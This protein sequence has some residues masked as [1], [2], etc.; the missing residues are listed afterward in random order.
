MSVSLKWRGASLVPS[1]PG[2][3][4]PLLV[5]D[6]DV[7]LY[8]VTRD[9]QRFLLLDTAEQVTQPLTVIVN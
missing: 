4:F 2:A 1:V 7:S 9:G 8:D 5:M 3:L 6:T